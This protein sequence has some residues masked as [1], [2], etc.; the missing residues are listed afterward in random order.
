MRPPAG[1]FGAAKAPT[2]LFF[3]LRAANLCST[4]DQA[5][6]CLAHPPRIEIEIRFLTFEFRFKSTSP[7]VEPELLHMPPA[8]TIED[9][10]GTEQLHHRQQ[11]LCRLVLVPDAAFPVPADREH[12]AVDMSDDVVL[13]VQESVISAEI[14]KIAAQPVELRLAVGIDQEERRG[15]PASA[16]ICWPSAPDR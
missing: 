7:N 14:D 2:S 8:L 13:L 9:D 4:N 11:L 15:F 16:A 1:A 3:K 6:G 10:D 5:T 12:A